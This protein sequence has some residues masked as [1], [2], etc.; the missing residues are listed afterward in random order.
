VIRIVSTLA[1]MVAMLG[2]LVSVSLACGASG[3]ACSGC[4]TVPA[5]FTTSVSGCAAHAV[6]TAVATAARSVKDSVHSV[7]RVFSEF[8][9]HAAHQSGEARLVVN[10]AS[11]KMSAVLQKLSSEVRSLSL[12][13]L[14]SAF[15]AFW[16][17]LSGL[18]R[19]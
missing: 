7:G 6:S 9:H 14:H 12:S 11:G 13:V 19:S 3:A 10:Q 5:R 2:L 18:L 8:R 4:A 17:L 1:V 15:S 16:G